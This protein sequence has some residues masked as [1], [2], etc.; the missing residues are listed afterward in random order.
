MAQYIINVVEDAK[1]MAFTYEECLH[2]HGFLLPGGA[3]HGFLALA[4]AIQVLSPNEAPERR[5]ISIETSFSGRGARDAIE[6]ITR[7]LTEGRYV[8]NPAM[9][10]PDRGHLAPYVFKFSYRGNSVTLQ[11]KEGHV[12]EDFRELVAK[13]ANRTPE[14]EERVIFLR[15]EMGD[16]LIALQPEEVYEVV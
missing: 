3:A 12:R 2:Y 9:A 1:P 6:M 8:V 14:E 16:R 4:R 11:V 5:E 13:G 10:N 7:S 15:K